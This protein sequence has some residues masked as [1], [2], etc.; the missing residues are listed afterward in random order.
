MIWVAG[1]AAVAVIGT[2]V[3][4]FAV[5]VGSDFDELVDRFE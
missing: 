1:L 5:I 4:W 3:C 2:A